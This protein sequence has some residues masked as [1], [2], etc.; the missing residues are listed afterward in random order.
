MSIKYLFISFLKSDIFLKST[1]HFS[2]ISVYQ[3]VNFIT[4][5]KRFVVVKYYKLWLVEIKVNKLTNLFV[6]VS[7]WK[8]HYKMKTNS[9]VK[10]KFGGWY[11]FE[12]NTDTKKGLR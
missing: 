6:P 2:G 12:I 9:I 4:W 7:D 5:L 8:I 10:D 3:K 11:P 1:I